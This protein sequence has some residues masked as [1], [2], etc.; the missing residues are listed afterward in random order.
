MRRAA[1]LAALLSLP[2][3][4]ERSAMAATLA[5]RVTLGA[6]ADASD[7][8]S[9]FYG[10]FR[11]T[12]PFPAAYGGGA[13]VRDQIARAVVAT[14]G[15]QALRSLYEPLERPDLDGARY[16]LYA[17]GEGRVKWENGWGVTGRLAT[18]E[19]SRTTRD[20]GRL[21]AR[22][23][24]TYFIDEAYARYAR[25]DDWR[26]AALGRMRLRVGDGFVHDDYQT[27]A[28]AGADL[29]LAGWFPLAFDVQTAKIEGEH[30]DESHATRWDGEGLFDPADA[31]FLTE[32]TASYPVSMLESVSVSYARFD[33]RDGYFADLFNPVVGDLVLQRAAADTA[34]RVP[35]IVASVREQCR[36]R[37][38]LTARCIVAGSDR[39]LGNTALKQYDEI[40]APALA[41]PIGG[42]R[43]FLNYAL[44]Q[45]RKFAGE[46]SL[47]WTVVGQWGR[48][49]LTDL[50]PALQR[51][52]PQGFTPLPA[53]IDFPAAGLLGYGALTYEPG[54][55][56]RLRAHYLFSSG[57]RPSDQGLLDGETYRSFIGVRPYVTLTNIFFSGGISENL[58]TGSLSPSGYYGHGVWA[59]V[60]DAVWTPSDR[61]SVTAVGA[62]LHAQRAPADAGVA[63]TGEYGW[64]GDLMLSYAPR[65]WL[66]VS[67]EADY[68]AAGAFFVAMPDVWKAAAGVDLILDA[69]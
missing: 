28:R 2:A 33:E 34:G 27:V 19:L 53:R 11:Q 8:Q 45:G 69:P 25:W 16:S 31:A 20:D 7:G 68:F 57:D 24:N 63:R 35:D 21:A 66:I 6:R 67:G 18:R 42:G 59:P 4:G 37:G 41:G 40:V 17:I 38:T 48:V 32:A 3:A 13:S 29:D 62:Y 1:A 43:S 36:S 39:V 47:E 50:S 23:R 64:E 15:Y 10:S 54:A 26:T 12:N 14:E 44:F 61:L 51:P 46:F 5:G 9:E 30:L 65:P 49:T 56:W 55:K 22:A 58:R 60:A 52:T